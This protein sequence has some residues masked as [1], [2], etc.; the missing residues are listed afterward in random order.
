VKTH[1]RLDYA[2]LAEALAESGLVDPKTLKDAL[3]CSRAGGTPFPA[4]LVEA[5]LVTDWDLS[6]VVCDI[7][8]L[9]FLPVDLVEP[10]PEA[11]LDMHFLR[12]HGLIPLGRYGQVL[13]ISM[14]GLVE[15]D[16]LGLLAAQTDLF[17]LPVVGTVRS[18]H[19]WLQTNVEPEPVLPTNPEELTGQAEGWSS[20]FDD[21]DAAVLMELQSSVEEDLGDILGPDIEPAAAVELPEE[22]LPLPELDLDPP[23]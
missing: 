13:T 9:P 11:F 17:L 4:A 22:P 16:T 2:R 10:S 23:A 15:A 14:P 18:N 3:Q 12:E 1:Q 8:G 7:Y 20:F 6:R 19:H 21:A 5:N